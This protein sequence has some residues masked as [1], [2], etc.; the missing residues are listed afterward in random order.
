VQAVRP[1]ALPALRAHTDTAMQGLPG[2]EGRVPRG[3]SDIPYARLLEG[4]CAVGRV[5]FMP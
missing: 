4:L 5:S 1:R 3:R 2:K